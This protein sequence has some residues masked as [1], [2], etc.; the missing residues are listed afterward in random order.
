MRWFLEFLDLSENIQR[1]IGAVRHVR[2]INAMIMSV[3][4][5]L[6]CIALAPLI[7]FFDVDATSDWT[8][9]GMAI[10][11]PELP[12]EM[13]QMLWLIVMALTIMPTLIE[14]FGS[15]FA[16]ANISAAAWL[17]YMFSAFDAITDWPRVEQFWAAFRPA[18]DAFGPFGLPI[19]WTIRAVWLFMASF[20]F[21]SLFV[22][23][24]CAAVVCLLNVGGQRAYA[25]Q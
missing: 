7:W 13:Q 21:E 8:Q 14:L 10:L 16:I 19:F 5:V 24:G 9:A 6:L 2:G 25:Q 20:G 23:F 18:F 22:V 17:V 1:G 12:P 3:V 11:L 15:R 4:L